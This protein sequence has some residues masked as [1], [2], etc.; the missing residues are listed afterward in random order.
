MN[1]VTSHSARTYLKSVVTLEASAK[2]DE[3]PAGAC[4]GCLVKLG[5][6]ASRVQ[7]PSLTG[8]VLFP[9]CQAER[10]A[11]LR[12]EVAARTAAQFLA[13]Q[14]AVLY[15]EPAPLRAGEAGTVFYNPG[16]TA[17][18]GRDEVWIRGSFNRW[19]HREGTWG[20]LKMEPTPDSGH[21]RASCE[22]RTGKGGGLPGVVQRHLV[23]RGFCGLVSWPSLGCPQPPS[24]PVSR[25]L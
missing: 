16:A 22:W 15:T 4:R 2:E 23:L 24:P 19:T 8:A 11:A 10:R 12:A 13:A 7:P 25:L 20:P 6:T 1:V 21:L 9:C 3:V 18:A 5:A 17:L 14:S